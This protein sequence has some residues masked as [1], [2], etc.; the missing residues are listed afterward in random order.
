MQSPGKPDGD[1]GDRFSSSLRSIEEDVGPLSPVQKILI[2]TDGSVTRLLEAFTGS[3]IGIVTLHQQTVESSPP[4]SAVLDV[5][6][7]EAV[8]HRIVEIRRTDTGAVLLHATSFTPLSR[9]EPEWR[10]DLVR[11]DVPIGKILAGHKIEA[12][13]ELL[14]VGLEP[15]GVKMAGIF[16][17]DPGDLLLKREYRIIHRGLPLIDIHEKFPLQSFSRGAG[18]VIR[19]PSRLHF[20]LIDLHGGLSRVD[21]GIGLALSHPATILSA[22]LAPE[23]HVEGGTPEMNRR[24]AEAALSILARQ[25]IS[26]GAFL[27][28]HASPPEHVGL[29]AGTALGLSAAR[30]VC[31]LYRI[32]LPVRDLA[33]AVGRGGTSGVGTGAFEFGGFLLDGGHSFGKSADKESFLPSAASKGLSPPPL[34]ARHAFPEEWKILLVIPHGLLRVYGEEERDLFARACPVPEGEVGETCREVIMRVLPGLVDH[35]LDLFSAGVNRIQHLGFKEVE[36][37][38]QPPLLG[39]LLRSLRSA[40]AACTGMSSFGPTVF[41]ITDSSPEALERAARETLQG[42]PASFIHTSAANKGALIRTL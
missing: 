2:T 32:E 25:G 14:D 30:A 20:G 18:V 36:R 42:M 37:S 41:C 34:I 19:A 11:A 5:N 29:G 8:N 28:L 24:A 27:T 1:A 22:R 10:Q 15:A 23:L 35:D 17:I 21:G 33:R 3:G 40:G 4:E 13:R 12:R 6:P 9:L 31:E 26:G 16:G 39:D 38:H 7:G